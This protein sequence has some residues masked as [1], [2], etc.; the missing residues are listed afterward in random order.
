DPQ[1]I[2]PNT[3]YSQQLT[4]LEGSPAPTWTVVQGPAGLQVNATGL[5]TGWTPT[6]F[7]DYFMGI[8]ATNSQGSDTESW[9]VCVVSQF[10]YDHDNDVD[11]SD[12]GYLQR[13]L[14]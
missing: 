13:C 5:V 9:T 12:F 3:P 14:S 10:D 6:V 7:G 8:E 2:I 11:I 1:F 4:L